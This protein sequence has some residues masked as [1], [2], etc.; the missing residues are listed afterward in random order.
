VIERRCL[1]AALWLV[2]LGLSG[3]VTERLLMPTPIIYALGTEPTY[4]NLDERR[5]EPTVEVLYVTDRAPITDEAGRQDYGIARSPSMAFGTADIAFGVDASWEELAADARRT[6]RIAPLVLA[7]QSVTELDRSPPFPVPFIIEDGRPV[8]EPAVQAELERVTEAF[9]DQIRAQLA[10]TSRKEVFIFVHG[11]QNSFAEAAYTVAELW[12]YFGREGVP[13][14]YTWP[15]GGGGLLRGYT[16]DRESSEFT[17]THMK[18]FLRLLTRMPEVEGVHVISHSRGTDVV[19]TAIRE[20]LIEAHAKGEDPRARYRIKNLV[21][22]AP[23]LDLD[24]MLQRTFGE[25]IATG[26]DRLTIYTS[27]GDKALGV[28]EMLFGGLTRVGQADELILPEYMRTT[29][30]RVENVAFIEYKGTEAG[31]FGHNYFRKNPAVASD[32]VLTVRYDR[33]P[34]AE[35]GRPLTPKGLIFWQIGD[36]YLQPAE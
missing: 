35:N 24:V 13:I 33:D 34:G 20:L 31:D 5:K 12:H 3:C 19:T 30:S 15:A 4:A 14:A 17:V 8:T 2:V 25:R 1:V 10:T 21:L 11:I 27:K 22:A 16:Y 28:S 23:D 29:A 9:N 26:V 6:D 7:I 18:T 32:L 36:R